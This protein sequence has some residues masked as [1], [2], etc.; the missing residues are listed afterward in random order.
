MNYNVFI[1]EDNL[2]QSDLIRIALEKA[3]QK[4][5]GKFATTGNEALEICDQNNFDII[6]LDYI[7]PDLSGIE[8]LNELRERNINTP[9]IIVTGQGDE[10]IA[11]EAMK[12]GAA[13][14]IVKDENYLK[15]MPKTITSIVDRYKLQQQLKEKEEFLANVIENAND[16]IFSLDNKF[17][18][19]FIN[20]KVKKLKYKPEEL[21]GKSFFS[22]L[23]EKHQPDLK[24]QILKRLDERNFEL[25]FKDKNGKSYFHIVSFTRLVQNGGSEDHILGIAKDMTKTLQL[26]RLIQESKK[27]LQTLFDSITDYIVVLD[28]DKNIVMANKK[29]AS[30][31][32]TT[33]NRILGKKCFSMDSNATS[34]CKGCIVDKTWK[35]LEPEYMER[36]QGKKIFQMWT[37]P[38]LNLDGDLEYVIEYSRDVTDQ[39]SFE[40]KL[41]QAE[42]LATIG[43]LASGVAHELRNPLNIIETAR[44]Y[45]Q[46]VLKN[47]DENLESKL[48]I[49]KRNVTRASNIIN[50]LLEFS[51]HSQKDRELIDVNLI[52]DKTLSLIDK[53]LRSQNIEVTKIYEEIPKAY[54]NI[55]SLKQVFLNII[56][57]AIHA[58]PEGGELTIQTKF[59]DGEW[60]KVKL[61]DTGTGIPKE[62]LNNIFTP[63][64][65]TKELGKGTGLGM[66]VSHSIIKRENGEILVDSIEGEG[67][68]FTVLLPVKND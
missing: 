23:S 36:T 51:R 22:I 39:K 48:Q 65:T 30:L 43:L 68:T 4:F 47:E 60:I 18:I 52:I 31:Q 37:Y 38:M 12:S 61:L 44:Y 1:V 24:E 40:R 45:L 28:R 67:T 17:N 20:P 15:S 7:L 27:K 50:N 13:D 14:Y 8:V 35:T 49:I 2:D 5:I 56:I 57:N 59:F 53:D 46:D 16:I 32:N 64:F 3:S 34:V 58:M 42:K 21:M 33:P 6:I 19:R 66:Y 9:V 41:I 26:H 63:F 62:N 10:R 11:V 29:V 54:L 55:D 25:E